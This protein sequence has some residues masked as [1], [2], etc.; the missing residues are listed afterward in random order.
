MTE[1]KRLTKKLLGSVA[2]YLRC[3]GVVNKPNQIK[4]GLLARLS[5]KEINTGECLAKLQART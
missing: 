4:K 5:V 3:V 2:A 1:D